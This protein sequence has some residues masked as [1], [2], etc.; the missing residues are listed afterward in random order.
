MECT[1]R[2]VHLAVKWF[3]TKVISSKFKIQAKYVGRT[4]THTRSFARTLRINIERDI[5][6]RHAMHTLMNWQCKK[7]A[8]DLKPHASQY[9]G[10]ICFVCTSDLL[11]IEWMKLS[12]GFVP[13]S[14]SLICKASSFQFTYW[15]DWLCLFSSS[16]SLS[17]SFS[18]SSG[19]LSP[20]SSV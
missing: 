15:L 20:P 7:Y 1:P 4:Y 11:F 2:T 18:F 16:Y 13:Y 10:L 3:K 8:V 14:P 6:G 12:S 17:L 9:N 19:F 5:Y